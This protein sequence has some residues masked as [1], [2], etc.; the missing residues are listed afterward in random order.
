MKTPMA[1][2]AAKAKYESADTALDSFIKKH[3]DTFEEYETLVVHRNET[4]GAFKAVCSDHADKLSSKFG[5]WRINIPRALNHEALIEELGE[6]AAEPYLKVKTTVDAK[7][8]DHGVANGDIA[9]SV[10]EAVEGD[11][12][13]R[14]TGPKTV[15]LY[16]R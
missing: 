15:T 11:G 12:S 9:E 2:T 16:T 5:P 8:Y 14:L 1:V 4:L 3:R 7:L 10:Q 6:D 13:P